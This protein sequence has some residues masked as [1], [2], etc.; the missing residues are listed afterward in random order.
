MVILTSRVTAVGRYHQ[1][2]SKGVFDDV[3]PVD[4]VGMAQEF[5]LVYQNAT[6]QY[7]CRGM[8]NKTDKTERNSITGR[9][10]GTCTPC[11]E[12][13]TSRLTPTLCLEAVR[14]LRCSLRCT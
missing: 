8:K 14:R 11:Q 5:V 1:E 4:G 9:I 7:F 3:L 6:I 12:I 2:F 10:Y 13:N